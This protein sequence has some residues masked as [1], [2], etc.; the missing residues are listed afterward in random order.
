MLL[1]LNTFQT[2]LDIY[3]HRQPTPVLD[4]PEIVSYDISC[5]MVVAPFGTFV[6]VLWKRIRS[7]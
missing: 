5:D 1:R 4:N 2:F 7:S 3:F 6:D